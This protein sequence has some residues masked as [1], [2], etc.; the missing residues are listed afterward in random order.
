[1]SAGDHEEDEGQSGGRDGTVDQTTVHSSGMCVV[2]RWASAIG[3][4]S[5][6]CY[7]QLLVDHHDSMYFE[8]CFS[9]NRGISAVLLPYNRITLL[10][11]VPVVLWCCVAVLLCCCVAVLLTSVRSR[12]HSSWIFFWAT[13]LVLLC[14]QTDSTLESRTLWHVGLSRGL[15]CFVHLHAVHAL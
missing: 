15:K 7:H 8:V 3:H 10:P 9:R 2:G 6:V 11:A 12:S 13:R 4:R 5:S 14:G 1:M